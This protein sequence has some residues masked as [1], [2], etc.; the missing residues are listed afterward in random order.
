MLIGP[1]ADAPHAELLMSTQALALQIQLA[2]NE[3]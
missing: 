3:G 1:L 2:A